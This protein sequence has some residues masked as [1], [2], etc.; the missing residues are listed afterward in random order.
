MGQVEGFGGFE[1]ATACHAKERLRMAMN[2][3]LG[4]N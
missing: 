2:L 4:M 3:L 1:V